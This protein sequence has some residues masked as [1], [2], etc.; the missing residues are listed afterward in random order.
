TLNI[1]PRGSFRQ[2]FV[3]EYP[4]AHNR[5]R[6]TTRAPPAL[7]CVAEE[8]SQCSNVVSDRCANVAIL[9]AFAANGSVDVKDADVTEPAVLL[10]E[11][12]EEL[13]DVPP[14]DADSGLSQTSLVNQ[15]ITKLLDQICVRA[16]RYF[17]KTQT[18][19][20]G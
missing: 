7:L 15:M 1:L 6:K 2:T 11:A 3:S 16:R 13:S 9:F 4:R 12:L 19:E 18:T 17:G 5:R 20:E 8:D 10:P 14:V